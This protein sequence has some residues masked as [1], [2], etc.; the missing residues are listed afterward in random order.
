MAGSPDDRLQWLNG[1]GVD[2]LQ[3]G[4]RP[5]EGSTGRR[6]KE[7]RMSA[8]NQSKVIQHVH[9]APLAKRRQSPEPLPWPGIDE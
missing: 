9:G 3:H 2:A 4:G 7:R 1:L 8:S 6:T 5:L